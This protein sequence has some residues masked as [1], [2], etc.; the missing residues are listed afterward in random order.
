MQGIAKVAI[1][2]IRCGVCRQSGEER[3]I[4]LGCP[5]PGSNTM[6][7]VNVDA[8]A[9]QAHAMAPPTRTD[10]QILPRIRWVPVQKSNCNMDVERSQSN[11]IYKITDT[12]RYDKTAGGYKCQLDEQW[13]DFTKD[14]LRDALQIT[15]VNSN[16]AFSSPPTLD[17][18]I[19]FVNDLG[20]RKAVR[21]LS[22]VVTNDMFQLWR[23][24]TKIINLCLTGKT[25]GFER[26][27]APESGE[28]LSVARHMLRTSIILDP[29]VGLQNDSKKANLLSVGGRL[30]LIKSKLG[31][32]GIYYLSISKV[33]EM[34]VKSLES[35][36]ATFFWGGHEDTKKISWVKWSILLLLLIKEASALAS[37]SKSE[38]LR[39]LVVKV[40]YCDE[41]GVDLRGCQMNGV[42]ASIVGTINHLHSSGI[43]RLSSIPFKD[44]FIR[45]HIVNGSWDWDWSRPITMGRTKT[46][47]D[48]LMLDTASLESDEIVG[49]DSCIWNLSNDD[50]LSV[51]KVRKHIDEC[52]L[53]MLSLSTRWYKIIPKKVNIFMWP[54]FLDRLPNRLNL[55]SRV[56]APDLW[57]VCNDYGVVVYAFIPYK[58]SKACKRFAFVW[59]IKVDNIDRLV[60]MDIQEK[61]KNRSQNDKTEHE[62]RK[63]C[64][65]TRS[66]SRNRQQQQVPQTFV[67]PFD[68]EEPI[69]NLA[70]PVVTMAD[71]RTM[72]QLLQAPTEGYE[73]AIVVPAITA[74]NFELKH[75]LLT[76]VQNK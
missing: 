46:E 2:G 67:E 32:L 6:A 72:A 22:D 76:L 38:S 49:S 60:V 7:D 10:D 35:L 59:L 1:G 43:I 27:R 71:N 26:P 68:L 20:Y 36:R 70:P 47:F 42:W 50:I 13:F 62:N 12:I 3:G 28:E 58:K 31:S 25:S 30:T 8:T 33:S 17:A 41:A 54:M 4:V 65:R 19:K 55:S 73:D 61:D 9:E 14:T 34:V 48:N 63:T 23:A 21:H 53:P 24:L 52:S 37:I 74:D 69:D 56:T 40:I 18:F 29:F 64:M 75:G 44:C 15:P 66:Q 11:P 51:N 5:F 16:N 57:K 45:E 39:V